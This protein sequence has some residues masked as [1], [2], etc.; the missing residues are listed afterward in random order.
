LT[1][2]FFSYSH[3]DETLRD[4]LE[5]QLA[6]M[7]RQSVIETWHDRR[8]GAGRDFGS[9]I[10]E[11]VDADNIILL[12]V[13]PDFLASDYCY[14]REMERAMARHHAGDAIVIPVILRP[15][16]WHGAPFGK[17]QATPLDGKP[18][19]LW[20][21][22]DEAFL[23]VARAIREAVG[24]LDERPRQASSLSVVAEGL[25]TPEAD[26]PRE[27]VLRDLLEDP[28][29]DLEWRTIET[30]SKSIGADE[31]ETTRLLL[32]VR[33]VRSTGERNVWRIPRSTARAESVRHSFSRGGVGFTAQAGAKRFR[34]FVPDEAIDDYLR[35]PGNVHW[36]PNRYEAFVSERVGSL[37]A[38]AGKRRIRIPAAS[39][40][41]V[42]DEFNLQ[43]ALS[44]D[45]GSTGD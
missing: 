8:I 16:D 9:A 30:L 4:Q 18:I 5:K 32:K 39:E 15:C 36:S 1:K 23:Q 2:V 25:T 6:V 35:T 14:D 31:T 20:S 28:R 12:L 37:A 19:T 7:K 27:E 38:F 11:H 29:P 41:I 45:D 43:E 44:L 3:A 42:L 21:D 34:V 26:D 33:A 40:E 10:D 22:R 17:L 13:S 24:R